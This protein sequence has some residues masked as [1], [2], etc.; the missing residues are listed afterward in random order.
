M[1]KLNENPYNFQIECKSF[2]KL[3]LNINEL[4]VKVIP[5]LPSLNISEAFV[6]DRDVFIRTETSLVRL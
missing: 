5:S 6:K 1:H 2:L 4:I 3:M